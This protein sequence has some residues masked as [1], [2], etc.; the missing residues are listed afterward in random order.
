MEKKQS[1][2]AINNI[3]LL[4]FKYMHGVKYFYN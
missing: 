2:I 3:F 1:I 4:V